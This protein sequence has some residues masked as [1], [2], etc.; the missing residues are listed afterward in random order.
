M[1]SSASGEPRQEDGLDDLVTTPQP[2]GN[3]PVMS[4]SAGQRGPLGQS[5]PVNPGLP[6][7]HPAPHLPGSTGGHPHSGGSTHNTQ[8]QQNNGSQSQQQQQGSGLTSPHAGTPTTSTPVEGATPTPLTP[9]HPQ[10]FPD[11][12]QT[13]NPEQMAAVL[14]FVDTFSAIH[15]LQTYYY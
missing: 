1:Q 8:T 14:P 3:N 10:R 4:G 12:R 11:P 9:S 15:N 2:D 5:H 13:Y 7:L 6:P